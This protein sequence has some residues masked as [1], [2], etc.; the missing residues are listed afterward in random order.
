MLL[1]VEAKICSM[2]FA[3][4]VLRGSAI[5]VASGK[6]PADIQA[7]ELNRLCGRLGV[8][9]SLEVQTAERLHSIEYWQSRWDSSTNRCWSHRLISNINQW[10]TRKHGDLDYCLTK[11]LSSHGCFLEYD[12][13]CGTRILLLRTPQRGAPNAWRS[14]GWAENLITKMI[15]SN[16]CWNAIKHFATMIVLYLPSCNPC[17]KAGKMDDS[18]RCH[19]K[20]FEE[21]K[22]PRKTTTM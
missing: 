13:K 16:T 18:I 1:R 6:L 20:D 2:Q 8:K 17:Y 12:W 22:D 14:S 4:Q 15:A 10:V 19:S 3:A 5:A 11:I 9:S 21:T 7:K